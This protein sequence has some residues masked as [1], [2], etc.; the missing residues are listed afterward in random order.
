MRMITL[1]QERVGFTRNE[2]LAVLVLGAGVLVSVAIRWW[3]P[4]QGGSALRHD[5]SR[6][7][8]I[9]TLRSASP[10]APAPGTAPR[11]RQPAAGLPAPGSIDLNT[12]AREELMRLPG[13][14]SVYAGR[15]LLYRKE[16]GNIAD[17]RELLLI[18]GIGPKTLERIRP[19]VVARQ[20]DPVP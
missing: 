16:R 9:F 13:I 11:R 4:A 18:R 5:H 17:I 15:I 12:A 7:D 1:L 10:S 2:S 8:S 19:Y 6:S 14:G 3:V 20:K